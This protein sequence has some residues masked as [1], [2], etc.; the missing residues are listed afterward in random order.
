VPAVER[1][2]FLRT[3]STLD[4]G[5]STSGNGSRPSH[6]TSADGM[7]SLVPDLMQQCPPASAGLP[8]GGSQI[9]NEV[10]ADMDKFF[11]AEC[12]IACRRGMHLWGCSRASACHDLHAMLECCNASAALTSSVKRAGTTSQHAAL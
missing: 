11:Q 12:A 2:S 5:R 7:G 1:P 9:E 8:K 3:Q 4:D 10:S 6:G